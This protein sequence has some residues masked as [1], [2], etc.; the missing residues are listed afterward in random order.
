MANPGGPYSGHTGQEITF[1]GSGSSDPNGNTLTYAWDFGDGAVGSG[2]H[3]T[4][5]Y[6][7]AGGLTVTLTVNNGHGGT[8]TATTTV[9]VLGPQVTITSPTNLALINSSPATV[10]GTVDNP[11]DHVFVNGVT[12]TVSGQ[13]F[14]AN[15]ILLQ[16]ATNV[17]T[18]TATDPNGDVGTASI[19]VGLDTTPPRVTI[20][21][22]A[23]GFVTTSPSI[24]VSGDPYFCRASSASAST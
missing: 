9:T 2:A 24:T 6:T 16:E 17:I 23:D 18:A 11:L 5:T 10:A 8:N 22:P 3:P 20:D 19:T 4:H 1:D 13:S 14:I 21:S 7:R 12:A 15:S